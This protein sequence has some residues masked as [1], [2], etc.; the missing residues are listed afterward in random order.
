[1]IT[2]EDLLMIVGR[3]MLEN[4]PPPQDEMQA[5]NFQA[6]LDSAVLKLPQL[7]VGLDVNV[8]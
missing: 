2:N 3:W 5:E 1:M 6:N 4:N 7:L 8:G